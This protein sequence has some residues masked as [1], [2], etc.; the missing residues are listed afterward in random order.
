[1]TDVGVCMVHGLVPADR[2]A[3]GKPYCPVI[4]APG[5][6][7][8]VDLEEAETFEILVCPTCGDMDYE[9]PSAEPL[10]SISC[11]GPADAERHRAKRMVA[12]RAVLLT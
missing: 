12:T 6:S 3:N 11:T 1:M 7:C 10:I 2:Q 9:P 8:G 4:V 5:D